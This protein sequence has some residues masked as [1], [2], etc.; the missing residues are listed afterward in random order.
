MSV[1]DYSLKFIQFAKYA[2][3]LVSDPRDEMSQFVT[4]VSDDLHEECHSA[5]LH[6]NTN[7]SHL[8]VHARRVEEARA[9]RKNRDTKRARSFEGRAT[10]NSLEIQDKPKFK[11]RFS[12]Q[13][14]SKFPKARDDKAPR[15]KFQK[16]KIGSLSN[17]KSTCGKCGKGHFGECLIGTGICLGC[18]KNCH[19]VMANTMDNARREGD[20]N[21]E[22]EIPP[23]S[24]RTSSSTSARTSSSSSS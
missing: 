19:K 6:D 20:G 13:V 1:H 8:M 24:L 22:Q 5:M 11:K 18:C 21:G 10:R 15:Q 2:P 17:E 16:G 23:P 4:G 7:I 14:P 3:S 9:K 12:N